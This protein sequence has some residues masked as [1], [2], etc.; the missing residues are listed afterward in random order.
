[1]RI[2]DVKAERLPDEG[3]R[4]VPGNLHFEQRVHEHLKLDFRRSG[5]RNQNLLI[6]IMRLPARFAKAPPEHRAGL[7]APSLEAA[8]RL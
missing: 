6:S 7:C 8:F 4:P 5:T 1:V 2:F 3:F